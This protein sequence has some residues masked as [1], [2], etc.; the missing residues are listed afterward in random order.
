MMA[1]LGV[2][3][4][5]SGIGNFFGSCPECGACIVRNIGLVHFGCCDKHKVG[6]VIGYNLFSGALIEPPEMQRDTNA[7]ISGYRKIHPV[8]SPIHVAGSA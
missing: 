2:I 8:Y 5:Q 7:L 1:D 3:P 4:L 6:W